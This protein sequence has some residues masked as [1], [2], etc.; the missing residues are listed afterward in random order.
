MGCKGRWAI[1]A[2]NQIRNREIITLAAATNSNRCAPRMFI[3]ERPDVNLHGSPQLLQSGPAKANPSGTM[4]ST[5]YSASLWS[6]SVSTGWKE[7]WRIG[8]VESLSWILGA[9]IHGRETQSLLQNWSS[10]SH[11]APR[12][13]W[14]LDIL[15][16]SLLHGV[17]HQVAIKDHLTHQTVFTK[18]GLYTLHG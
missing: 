9:I 5:A 7:G 4:E 8:Q 14:E 15:P 11:G 13:K 3:I 16:W 2:S 12:H 6:C 17:S 18:L 10:W 1:T